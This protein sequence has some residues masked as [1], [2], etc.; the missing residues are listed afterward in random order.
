MFKQ[1]KYSDWY[2]AI[3]ARARVDINRT[4]GKFEK[5]HVIP[6]SLGGSNEPDNLVKLTPR[7]HFICHLLLTKMTH[8]NHLFKMVSALNLMINNTNK[9]LGRTHVTNRK[10]N[11]SR[12]YAAVTF[13][14]EHKR[15]LSEAAKKRAPRKETAEANEKRRQFM[16]EYKKTPE[17]RAKQAASQTGQ[18]RGSWGSHSQETK[19]KISQLHK[20]K[21]KSEEHRKKI[22]Q[23]QLGKK[24]GPY[25]TKKSLQAL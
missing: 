13:S 24:R 18:I 2:N 9:R 16:C 6:K 25:K 15:K 22:G 17:H 8:G 21:P 1:N 14:D 4:S 20:G 7:E 5:H 3:I 23:N 12:F 11:A 10:Y 19:D